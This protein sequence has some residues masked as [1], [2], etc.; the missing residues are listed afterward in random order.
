VGDS[1]RPAP[2]EVT[3]EDMAEIDRVAA[4]LGMLDTATDPSE[5]TIVQVPGASSD[6]ALVSFVFD[7]VVPRA[8][9]TTKASTSAS[10]PQ[11]GDYS[12]HL[13]PVADSIQTLAA[14]ATT[15][16]KIP[17]TESL[18][19]SSSP[20]EEDSAIPCKRKS[21]K[22]PMLR[23]VCNRSTNS[24]PAAPASADDRDLSSG[25]EASNG[26]LYGPTLNRKSKGN[27]SRDPAEFQS[28]NYT[29]SSKQ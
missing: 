18:V 10:A 27:C 24:S 14:L 2:Q 16:P 28:F 11:L 12:G 20:L 5:D 13:S 22:H 29:P 26:D 4:S 7:P 23:M 1:S 17:A 9:V 3:P 25:D 15:V 8:T 21:K 6:T 19:S